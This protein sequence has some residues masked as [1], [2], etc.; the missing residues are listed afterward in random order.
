MSDD[1]NKPVKTAVRER[2]HEL[3]ELVK[4]RLQVEDEQVFEDEQLRIDSRVD[5]EDAFRDQQMMNW[6][7][8]NLTPEDAARNRMRSSEPILSRWLREKLSNSAWCPAVM[9]CRQ[10]PSKATMRSSIQAVDQVRIR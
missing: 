3:V 10:A 1:D 2:L 4:A 7:P 8:A 5:S 6:R 9:N